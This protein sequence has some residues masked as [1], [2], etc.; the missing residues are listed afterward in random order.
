MKNKTLPS[1]TSSLFPATGAIYFD[2]W[3]HVVLG[4]EPF[5]VP[6]HLVLYSGIG[7][8]KYSSWGF[9]RAN[10]INPVRAESSQIKKPEGC[11]GL[12]MEHINYEI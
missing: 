12:V 4:R 7:I 5:W 2:A 10:K 9:R 6:P 3:W 8:R 1:G 11:T